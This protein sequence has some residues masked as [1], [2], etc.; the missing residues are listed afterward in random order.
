MTHEIS[1][2][3]CPNNILAACVAAA[4]FTGGCSS[5]RNEGSS[6]R[7]SASVVSS[8]VASTYIAAVNSLVFSFVTSTI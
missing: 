5:D 6:A 8:S 4:L 7:S 1:Q 3:M 2:T